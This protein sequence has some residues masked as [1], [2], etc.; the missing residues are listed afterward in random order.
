MH[1][2]PWYVQ[3][4]VTLDCNCINKWVQMFRH[5]CAQPAT[6]GKLC[7][8]LY[9]ASPGLIAAADETRQSREFRSLQAMIDVY[10]C[11]YRKRLAEGSVS[12]RAGEQAFKSGH[13]QIAVRRILDLTQVQSYVKRRWYRSF[14][15]EQS[16]MIKPWCLFNL[17]CNCHYSCL[18]PMS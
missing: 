13:G 15:T 11:I 2:M 1:S 5:L 6:A 17:S 16:A 4:A 7:R 14:M 9:L 18:T 3:C 8:T 10:S 12:C